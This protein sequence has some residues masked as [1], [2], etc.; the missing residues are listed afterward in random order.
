MRKILLFCLV[1]L[2]LTPHMAFAQYHQWTKLKG[3]N[4]FAV[5]KEA[6]DKAWSFVEARIV[7]GIVSSRLDRSN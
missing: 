1:L 5:S 7:T 2:L 4:F 6:Y 3:D